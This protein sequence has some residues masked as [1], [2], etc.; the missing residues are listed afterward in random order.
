MG[1]VI[2]RDL[3]RPNR[4]GS[5]GRSVGRACLVGGVVSD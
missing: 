1:G 2:D 5:G 3:G 4:L